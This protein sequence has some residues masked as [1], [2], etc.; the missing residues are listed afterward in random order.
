LIIQFNDHLNT[1]S[2]VYN[3]VFLLC[4]YPEDDNIAML[5]GLPADD[6]S[7]LQKEDIWYQALPVLL[8]L[9]AYSFTGLFGY[10]IHLYFALGGRITG[11]IYRR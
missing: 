2:N 10:V 11:P 7:I 8:Y 6:I 1:C 3:A 5:L 9:I 4:S